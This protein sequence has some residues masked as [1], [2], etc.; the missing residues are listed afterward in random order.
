MTT[1]SS[2]TSKKTR[3]VRELGGEIWAEMKY[4]VDEDTV[5]FDVKH[6]LADLIMGV[7]ARHIGSEIVDDDGLP[8]EPLDEFDWRHS[9]S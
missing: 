7:L 5:R 9:N 1:K 3:S 8:V 2:E 6:Q 4:R